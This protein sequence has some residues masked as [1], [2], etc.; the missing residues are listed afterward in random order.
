ME[1]LLQ[2]LLLCI[3]VVMLSIFILGIELLL[4]IMPLLCY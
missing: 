4:V 3:L 1:F 2:G